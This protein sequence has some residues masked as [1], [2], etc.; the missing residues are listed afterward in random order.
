MFNV[1]GKEHCLAAVSRHTSDREQM[2]TSIRIMHFI[3]YSFIHMCCYHNK[4]QVNHLKHKDKIIRITSVS[5]ART[6]AAHHHVTGRSGYFMG[7]FFL[8]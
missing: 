2:L 8:A 7:L 1:E 4:C 6:V 5:E 3:I